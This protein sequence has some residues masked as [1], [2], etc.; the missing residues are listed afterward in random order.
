[1]PD[2]EGIWKRQR[3]FL[4]SGKHDLRHGVSWAGVSNLVGQFY[5]EYKV[6]NSFKLGEITTETKDEGT[7]FHDELMPQEPITREAFVELVSQ[8]RPTFAVL[9]VWG[10][11]GEVGL[12]GEPDHIVWSRAKPRWLVELK[13]TVRGDPATLWPDQRAQAVIYGA[14]LEKMG[15]DCS[16]LRLA[17]IRLRAR[18]LSGEERRD[19]IRLVSEGL[20]SGRVDEL[21]SQ[22]RGKMKVHLLR[23]DVAEAESTVRGFQ[24]YWLMKREPTSSTSP[25]KCRACEYNHACSRSLI[26]L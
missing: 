3:E 6:E 1:M 17:V 5:C 23:H 19:W 11:L 25:N 22:H 12:I 4:E 21:E 8:S 24:D 16:E 9:K 10:R 7:T 20:E 13:T 18:E 15:F 26:R 14:L 2:F